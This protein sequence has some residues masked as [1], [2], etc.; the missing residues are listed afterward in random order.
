MDAAA[1][2]DRLRAEEAGS[3]LANARL[4]LAGER[5]AVARAIDA[6]ARQLTR[7]ECQGLLDEFSDASGR[8]L[9]TALEAQGVDASAYLARVF[10]YDAPEGACG[11]ANLAITK[12]G[13]RAI[14][15]CG[16]R[17]VSQM[18]R[19]SRHVEAL[20]IHEMLHSLGLGENPPSSDHITSRVLARC[21]RRG[22]ALSAAAVAEKR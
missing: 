11:T 13:S 1:A 16:P 9:R 20:V 5:F 10:F 2:R 15:V 3:V 17:F 12:P 19:N 22:S 8:P 4:Q 6:A 21:G 7:A 18:K 14:L